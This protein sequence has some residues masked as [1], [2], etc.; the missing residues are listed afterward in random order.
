MGVPATHYET[1]GVEATA[2]PGDLRRAYLARARDLHPDRCIDASPAVRERVGRR[3]QEVNEAWRVLGDPG[4]RQRYDFELAARL[5]R[6]GEFVHRPAPTYDPSYDP[7]EDGDPDWVG[8]RVDG[9]VRLVRG[10]PWV[11]ILAVLAAIFV[12]TAYAADDSGPDGVRGGG[13]G[14]VVVA[15]GPVAEAESCGAEGAR[16]VVTQIDSSQ[17]C[18]AGTERLQ[19]VD[20]VRALCL[21]VASGS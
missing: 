21:E 15:T 17:A 5:V 20:S 8:G 3:M 10:L 14:C 9:P 7:A 16:R 2:T 12:F 18:P 11:V 19:P 4:R 13:G 1:L 6:P